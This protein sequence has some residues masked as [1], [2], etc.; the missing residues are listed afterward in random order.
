MLGEVGQWDGNQI[1]LGN[2]REPGDKEQRERGSSE[3]EGNAVF[4]RGEAGL[5]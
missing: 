1:S 3:M 2:C 4:L 5:K